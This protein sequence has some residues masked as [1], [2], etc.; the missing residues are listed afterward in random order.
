MNARSR[1][2][3]ARRGLLVLLTVAMTLACSGRTSDSVQVQLQQPGYAE[4]AWQMCRL[5]NRELT[6]VKPCN[7]SMGRHL[8]VTVPLDPPTLRR[9][10]IELRVLA[11]RREIEFTRSWTIRF[12]SA[13]SSHGPIETCP[14]S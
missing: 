10:C 11:V 3:S 12:Y 13:F 8:D 5:I 2:F 14:L 6:P 4:E 7:V 1:S 9:L